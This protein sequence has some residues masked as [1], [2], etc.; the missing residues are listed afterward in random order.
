MHQQYGYELPQEQE[1]ALIEQVRQALEADPAL[2]RRIIDSMNEILRR[3][4][5]PDP[6]WQ[7]R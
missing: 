4:F 6:R 2:R 3:D 1:Q 7:S 5:T